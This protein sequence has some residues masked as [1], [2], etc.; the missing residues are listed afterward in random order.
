MDPVVRTSRGSVRGRTQAGLSVFLG[1]PF[2]AAPEGP[3]RFELPAPAAPWNGVRDAVAFGVAPP[4]RLGA[5]YLPTGWRPRDG[6]DCLTV[7]VWT[8]AVGASGL[9]V[10]V[11]IYG[12]AWK[13]G[14]SSQPAY[15]GSKLARAGVVFVSF[16]YRVGFEGFGALPDAPANRWLHDQVAAL[17][18]V[19]ENIAAFGGAP[20]NVTVFGESAGAGSIAALIA[21]RGDR[22]LFRRAIAQSIPGDILTS[23]EAERVTRRLAAEAGILA[24]REGF[25]ALAPEAIL[26]VQDVPL[27]GPEDGISAFAPVIDG[28]IITAP[29]W[30]VIRGGAGR[31]IDLICGFMHEEWRLLTAGADLS[32]VDLPGVATALKLAPDAVSA[33]RAAYPDH[34]DA[35]PVHRAPLRRDLSDADDLGRRS[36]RPRRRTNLALRLHLAK[37]RA[38]RRATPSTWRSPSVILKPRWPWPPRR[39]A[40]GRLRSPLQEIRDAWVAFAATGDPGLAA[41]RARTRAAPASGTPRRPTRLTH[42]PTS[43]RIWEHVTPS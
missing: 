42:S 37:P 41:L 13:A 23:D 21:A 14:C 6:L 3:L 24:T 11:W 15:D 26:A 34:T 4:Q 1:I 30:E 43:R 17:G 25:A 38:R 9:P 27:T 16:N 12:G 32:S 5:P 28:E 10:M 22:G 29:P 18:W 35:E 7:N 19:Q 31:E 20:E 40:T 33:Y 36:P 2:A 8:P 39:P